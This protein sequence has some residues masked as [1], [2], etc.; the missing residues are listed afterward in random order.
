MGLKLES[1]LL[2]RVERVLEVKKSGKKVV[3]TNGVFDLIHTGHVKLLEDSKRLGDFLVVALNTDES[4]KKI[5]GKKR[6]IM[7]LRERVEILEAFEM[8]DEVLWFNE[9]T[10]YEIILK[11]KPDIIVKGGDYKPQDVVGKD[12]VESYGGKV[13]I[14]PLVKGYSTT[15]IIKKIV[16]SYR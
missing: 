7:S 13:I 16:E 15:K 12:I 10:P 11:I 5:K 1:E 4:V 6:P 2:R 8:V 9:E 3:F 14:V